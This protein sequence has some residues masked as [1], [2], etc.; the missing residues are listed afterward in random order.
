MF[1]RIA[2]RYL[3]ALAGLALLGTAGCNG[4]R[5]LPTDNGSDP[6]LSAQHQANLSAIETERTLSNARYDALLKSWNNRGTG[7]KPMF[8]AT[9]SNVNYVACAP[10]PF[11]GSAQIVGPAGGVFNF[12]PHKL[13]VPAGALSASVS[14][15]VMVVSAL[16]TEVK[17]L[18]HGTQFSVPVKLKLAYSHCDSATSHRVA[19]VDDNGTLLEW[20]AAVDNPSLGFVEATLSHFSIYAVAY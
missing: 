8:A 4:T 14:I 6:K 13:T 11:D 2:T 15:A 17:L 3:T 9:G 16:E 18:P 7:E 12:G 20:T 1:H 5:T 10:L 19:Y